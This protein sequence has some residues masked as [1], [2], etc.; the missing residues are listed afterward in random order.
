MKRKT[1]LIPHR[2]FKSHV[3]L[4]LKLVLEELKFLFELRN[5]VQIS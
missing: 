5:I 4:L 3:F 2:I 1:L